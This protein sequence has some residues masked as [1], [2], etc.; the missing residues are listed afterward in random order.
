M[1]TLESLIISL[2]HH[3][4]G[5]DFLP[6]LLFFGLLIVTCG[7]STLSHGMKLALFFAGGV[8][9]FGGFFEKIID[10]YLFPDLSSYVPLVLGSITAGLLELGA[11]L[12]SNRTMIIGIFF[13]GAILPPVF[14]Y[15][16]FFGLAEGSA[17]V[18]LI[19]AAGIAICCG[20][21]M[22]KITRT[23]PFQLIASTAGGA[24]GVVYLTGLPNE[25]TRWAIMTTDCHK[26]L[27]QMITNHPVPSAVCLAISGMIL[28]SL[29][30]LLLWQTRRLKTRSS[31][32]AA[33]E[34]NRVHS[35][36]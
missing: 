2:N 35:T 1:Q 5:L 8:V 14:L 9:L 34:R 30:H 27:S 17:A 4:N 31:T 36:V 24:L 22:L 25:L 6:T 12:V 10:K 29:I 16:G 33:S 13:G 3:I 21:A 18:P 20:A 32:Y 7:W 11:V 23:K 15:S 19:I 28:Q 26:A